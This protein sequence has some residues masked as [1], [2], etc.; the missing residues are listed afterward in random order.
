MK[1]LF[2]KI[3]NFI[4]THK[5]QTGVCASVLVL[6]V[7]AGGVGLA[8]QGKRIANTQK[9]L[10]MA[11]ENGSISV[12]QLEELEENGGF[13]DFGT[14]IVDPST[15]E[16]VVLTQNEDGTIVRT[17]VKDSSGVS[18]GAVVPESHHSGGGSGSGGGSSSGGDTPS[19]SPAG[20]THNFVPEYGTRKVQTGTKYV[21]DTPAQAAVTQE[22]LVHGPGNICNTC[23]YFASSTAERHAHEHGGWH[24][25]GPEYN[26]VVVSPAV[27]EQG[28]YEA[29]YDTEQYI[30][31]YRCECGATQ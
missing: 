31:C 24:S 19:P 11:A 13:A 5:W 9:A 18:T 23:G 17:V 1:N 4:R 26:T 29:V 28:H 12:E 16:T 20:H 15:G 25:C 8:V 6:A 3:S 21:V 10:E 2:N 7:G 27:A 30:V 22:V 14:E